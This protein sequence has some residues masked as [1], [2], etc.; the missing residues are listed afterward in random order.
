MKGKSFNVDVKYGPSNAANRVEECVKA[1][2]RMHIHETK[3]DILAFLTGSED[4]ENARK[5]C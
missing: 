2:I 4:C 1:S 5:L 3:G